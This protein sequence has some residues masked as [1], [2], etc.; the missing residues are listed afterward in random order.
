MLKSK[1]HRGARTLACR[2]GSL[3]DARCRYLA[4]AIIACAL[5]SPSLLP[6]Q[7]GL[8]DAQAFFAQA[9]AKHAPDSA[10]YEKGQ[11]AID[12]RHW[13]EAVEAFGQV[14]DEKTSR[15]DGALYW[16]AYAL[17]KLGRRDQALTTIAHLRTAYPDSRWLDDAKA[18]EIEIRQ[19]SGQKVNPDAEPDEDLKLMALRGI[20]DHDPERALPMIQKI[21]NGS[22]SPKLKERALFVLA[23]SDSPK[24]REILM[25]IA[26]GGSNPDLQ[27]K[28]VQYIAMMGGKQSAQ[29]LA[30]LYAGANDLQLKRA[31]L[32]SF[33]ISG[34]RDHLFQAAKSEKNPDLRKEAIHQLGISGGQ[35]EL[36]QLYQAEPSVEIKEEILHSMFVG[37]NSA[38][39][40][41]LVHTEKDPRLR[42]AAIHSLGLMGGEQTSAALV[43]MYRSE[44][45][46]SL[47]GEV[48]NALFIQGNA[49]ALIELARQENDPKMKKEIVGRLSLMGSKEGTEYLMELLN[50]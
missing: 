25:Q 21:M 48:I 2:V 9:A 5:A 14:A 47:R 10:L 42:K 16:K 22:Q 33:M 36:W 13:D 34:D 29:F 46:P 50:K 41:E 12:A 30:E 35:N 7:S 28:A 39:L 26:R 19:A 8:P 1:N 31:I 32:H 27:M 11:K 24:A 37:G 40:I 3:A 17:N 15:A 23:Q 43:S 20:M 38:K 4:P 44:S 49:K 45:D 18:I 6:A